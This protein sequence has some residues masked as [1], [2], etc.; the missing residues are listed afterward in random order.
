MTDDQYF[1]GTKVAIAKE[2]AAG[3]LRKCAVPVQVVLLVDSA[4]GIIDNGGLLYF[5]EVDF[6]EQGPYSDFVEAYRAIGAEEAATLLERSIRL[7]PFLDPHLH[8][9]KRQRWLDQIQEDEN[10]EFN[11]LSDKLIG[12]K[13]VFPKLKEYMARHWEHFGAT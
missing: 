8:E 13:A 2:K 10:H 11:D 7:F 5:Y 6:E 1:A 12:H 4:Q 9:L 3:A